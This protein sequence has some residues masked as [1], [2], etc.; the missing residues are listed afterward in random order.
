MLIHNFSDACLRACYLSLGGEGL[1][2]EVG[3]GQLNR[4]AL[5]IPL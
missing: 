4:R 5:R 2:E 1:V 3:E